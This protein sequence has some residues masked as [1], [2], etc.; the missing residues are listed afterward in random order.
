MWAQ[1]TFQV[2]HSMQGPPMGKAADG[3]SFPTACTAPVKTTQQGGSFQLSY[4]LVMFCNQVY[5]VFSNRILPSSS[6]GRSRAMALAWI[7]LGVSEAS[8]TIHRGVYHTWHEDF[9]L[10]SYD[11]TS[12]SSIIHL[13]VYLCL[14]SVLI[15]F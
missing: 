10:I 6:G 2:N 12:K 8:L 4:S 13:L 9:Y 14:D 15:I 5:D 3:F 1:L 11:P 7:V